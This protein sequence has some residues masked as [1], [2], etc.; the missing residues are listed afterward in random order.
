MTSLGLGLGAENTLEALI[1]PPI[2]ANQPPSPG[3][4]WAVLSSLCPH[5]R[6]LKNIWQAHFGMVWGE[7]WMGMGETTMIKSWR[8]DLG[9]R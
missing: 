6:P 2:L 8:M 3:A 4:S 7:D 1:S 9:R 5:W